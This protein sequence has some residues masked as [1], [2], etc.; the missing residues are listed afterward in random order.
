M[1][2]LKEITA[3]YNAIAPTV[4]M[5]TVNRFSS[6]AKA[7]AAL[8]SAKAAGATKEDVITEGDNPNT[9]VRVSSSPNRA[10]Q[11]IWGTK[12][13]TTG[14]TNR[15]EKTQGLAAWEWL[16]KKGKKGATGNEIANAGDFL[17]HIV[18]DLKKNGTVELIEDNRLPAHG[19]PKPK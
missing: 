6:K 13:R 4:G 18:W 8:A 19:G 1:A 5:K 14:E 11:K 9:V 16:A 3:K 15:K 12:F 2:T 17:Q 10:R 7:D